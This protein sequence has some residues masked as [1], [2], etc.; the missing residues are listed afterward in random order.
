MI[1]QVFSGVVIKGFGRGSKQLGYPTANIDPKSWN[2][3]I[4]EDDYGVYCGK[5]KIEDVQE[6]MCVFSVGKNLSF[7][8][9]TPTF[10]VH[11]L[12]FDQDI[13]GKVIKVYVL[14]HM[15]SMKKFNSINELLENI[16]NDCE[17]TRSFFVENRK[18]FNA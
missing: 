14:K 8:L 9:E 11:I 1:G 4:K 17:N 5:C 7:G 18:K 13:Y 2:Y 12:D 16:R 10:E 3:K 6:H 15:R